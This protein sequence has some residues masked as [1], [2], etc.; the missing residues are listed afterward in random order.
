MPEECDHAIVSITPDMLVKFCHC[1]KCDEM[2][3]SKYLYT[4]LSRMR[5]TLDT[6]LSYLQKL[7]V[8]TDG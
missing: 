3:D 8:K 6:M 7:G 2:V 4:Y 1:D 5:F